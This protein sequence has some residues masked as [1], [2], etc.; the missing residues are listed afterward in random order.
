MVALTMAL[1]LR[2]KEWMLPELFLT[3]IAIRSAV[4]KCQ[5]SCQNESCNNFGA[6]YFF[7]LKNLI[8]EEFFGPLKCPDGLKS[9]L[10]EIFITIF[11]TSDAKIDIYLCAFWHKS[12]LVKF[13]VQSL[14]TQLQK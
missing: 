8:L 3:L 1:V 4:K 6:D 14:I 12:P 5:K 2:C 11:M 13:V 9:A 7:L 10:F